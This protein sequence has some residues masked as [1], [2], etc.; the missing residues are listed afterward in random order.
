M[1]SGHTRRPRVSAAGVGRLRIIGSRAVNNTLASFAVTELRRRGMR[2]PEDMSVMG[3]GGED[4]PGVTCH[5]I[6]WYL[7]GRTAVQILLRASADP[8]CSNTEHLLSP[9]TLRTGL[10]TAAPGL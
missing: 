3:A 4:V 2:V 8:E 10:T 5:Q 6:G 7:M 1:R 9:H